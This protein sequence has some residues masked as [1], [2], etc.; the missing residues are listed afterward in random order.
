MP[1]R[2]FA[3]TRLF[4]RAPLS[5][6][7]SV[8]LDSKQANYL[9]NVLRLSADSHVLVFNGEDGEWRGTLRSIGRRHWRLE[10]VERTRPQ[11]PRPDLQLLF[12]PL[13]Q[14]RQDYLV[15][16]AVEMGVGRLRPVSTRH[17]QVSRVNP[18]RMESNAIE[19]AEQCGILTLPAIDELTPLDSLFAAWSRS[20]GGRHIVFCDEAEDE[21]SDAIASL[22]SLRSAPLAVLIGPEGGFA[23]EERA[24][25]RAAAFVTPISLGPR[26]LRADTA[27]VA[28]LALVQATVGDWRTG[29]RA[30]SPLEPF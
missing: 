15:E 5:S 17:S 23:A 12:A 28:V 19:A 13:K 18:G 21:A 4:V 27:A 11:P 24:T 14:A 3:S 2:D 8:D 26:I 20:E 10:V 29:D 22:V 25:L 7:E 1:I 9:V 16:K 30:G 6:G